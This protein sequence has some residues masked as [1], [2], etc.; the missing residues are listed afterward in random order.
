MNAAFQLPD[1]AH[2]LIRAAFDYWQHIHP[3]NAELPGR[4]HFD[5]LHIPHL[6]SHVWL[7]D[8]LRDAPAAPAFRYRVV[9]SAVDRGMGRTLTGKRLDEAIPGFSEDRRLCGPYLET[10]ETAQPSYRK[11]API[12]QHNRQYRALERLMMPLAQD[13][14]LVDML[15][16]I[17]L[18][19]GADGRLLGSRF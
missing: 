8:V 19:Y 9:G 2:P 5:P 15:F 3:A 16:C 6:L 10:V 1:T 13:G 11:G 7:V 4:Q 14:R 17:T 18:F 12:F